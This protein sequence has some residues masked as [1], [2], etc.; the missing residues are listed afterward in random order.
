[1][2]AGGWLRA[3][4]VICPVP[5]HDWFDKC[6]GHLCCLITLFTSLK[7]IH[8]FFPPCFHLFLV[9]SIYLCVERL[10]FD[11]EQNSLIFLIQIFLLSHNLKT[12]ASERAVKGR[13]WASASFWHPPL[14]DE[15]FYLPHLS[16]QSTLWM[17]C[18]RLSKPRL[19]HRTGFRHHHIC[20]SMGT[21]LEISWDGEQIEI[22]STRAGNGGRVTWGFMW[23]QFILSLISLA[24]CDSTAEVTRHS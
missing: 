14:G 3:W 6:H 18:F 21:I 5:R 19:F 24:Q 20:G 1:M 10:H 23:L 4:V 12:S 22:I 2:S 17:H 15:G 16:F 11:V 9:F 7:N 13:S 8:A